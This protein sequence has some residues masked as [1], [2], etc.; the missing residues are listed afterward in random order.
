M[1]AVQ[2]APIDTNFRM[3]AIAL[4]VTLSLD[5]LANGAGRISWDGYPTWGEIYALFPSALADMF[6]AKNAAANYSLLYSSKGV[7]WILAGWGAAWLFERTG[8]WSYAFT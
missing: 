6:G 5:P 2:L 3:G 4:A 8:S 1:V 7:C